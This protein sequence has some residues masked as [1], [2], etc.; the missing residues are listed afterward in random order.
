MVISLSAG[1]LKYQRVDD[2]E[3]RPAEFALK[4]N[5]LK[6]FNQALMFFGSLIVIDPYK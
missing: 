1:C 4:L 2:I 6:R 5:L 3:S